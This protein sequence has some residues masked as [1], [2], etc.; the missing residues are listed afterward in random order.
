MAAEKRRGVEL[1]RK[2]KLRK[3]RTCTCDLTEIKEQRRK[4]EG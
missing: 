2:K 4:E 1:L 3:E